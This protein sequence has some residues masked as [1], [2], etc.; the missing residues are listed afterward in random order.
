MM[1][2]TTSGRRFERS[3]VV[4]DD[5][6]LGEVI[7]DITTHTQ[8]LVRGEVELIKTE[9]VE[10]AKLA[11]KY[12]AMGAGAAIFAVVALVLLGHTIAQGLDAVMPDW[13]AYLITT[14]LFLGVAAVLGLMAKKGFANTDLAPTDGVEHAK[15]DVKWVMTHK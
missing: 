13:A 15:E 7:K 10:K 1:D 2:G 12:A 5:R 6:S 14:A 9:T 11:G 4:E 3:T 8:M